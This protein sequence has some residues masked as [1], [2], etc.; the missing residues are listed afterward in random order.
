MIAERNLWGSRLV[1]EV[2]APNQETRAMLQLQCSQC[3]QRSG[4]EEKWQKPAE[5]RADG[6]IN[7]NHGLGVAGQAGRW[8]LD[9]SREVFV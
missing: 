6:E 3:S 1:G 5:G 7:P 8:V 4:R 2:P 9:V